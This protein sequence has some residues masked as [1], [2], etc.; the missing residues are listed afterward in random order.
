MGNTVDFA[1]SADVSDSMRPIL[2]QLAEAGEVG[3]DVVTLVPHKDAHLIGFTSGETWI[4]QGDPATGSLRNISR[5]VGIIAPRAWCKDHDTVYWLSARGLYSVSAD[6]SGLKAVSADKIPV[7]LEDISDASCSLAYN[8]EDRGVYIHLTSGVSWFYDTER[9][10]FWPFDTDSTDS[11]LLLGPLRLGGPNDYGMIQQIHG[12]MAASSASVQWRI[13]PGDTAEEA[14]SNGK[15]AITA[16][17]AGNDYDE[18]ISSSGA[19]DAGRS[20]IGW[21]RAKSMWFCLWLSSTGTWA[22]ESV[23]L[24]ITPFGRWRG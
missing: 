20:P 12:I 9:D 3:S 11:H 23:L 24:T 5:E 17:L 18:Y 22:Y 2:F 15:L 6:G 21:P 7:E 14:A 13:V 4:L 16:A 10:Q 1:L 19:W 8:H